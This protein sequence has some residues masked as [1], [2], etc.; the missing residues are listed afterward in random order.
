MDQKVFSV[1]QEWKDQEYQ[2]IQRVFFANR[3]SFDASQAA[4]GLFIVFASLGIMDYGKGNHFASVCYALLC[5]AMIFVMGI[6]SYDKKHPIFARWLFSRC[7]F[8]VLHFYDSFI[9]AEKNGPI[10]IFFYEEVKQVYYCDEMIFL[11]YQKDSILMIS[12][13][14]MA[15]HPI[16]LKQKLNCPFH[17]L[18]KKNSFSNGLYSS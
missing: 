16:F 5:G 10:T 15:S 17:S 14:A 6:L 8:P 4:V 2:I 1:H 3:K 7:E 9:Q 18:K 13:E 12:Q 11:M